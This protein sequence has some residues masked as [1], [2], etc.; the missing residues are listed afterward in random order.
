MKV[1]V[2]DLSGEAL[3]WAVAIAL[4][5]SDWDGECFCTDPSGY[6]TGFF[7]ANFCPST[8]WSQGG[9]I[10]DMENITLIRADN[11]Y[12]DGKWIS[13]WFAES[14]QWGGHSA[15]ESYEHQQ[16]AP[17]FMIAEDGGEYGQAPLV[18]AMRC[19]VASKIGD[20]VYIPGGLLI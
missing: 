18:A 15:S 7:M 4:G 14:G 10:I 12:V 13:K 9:P 1:K 11:D 17:T 5:Y 2:S 19:Y 16:M 6:P 20:Y 8:D 3:D